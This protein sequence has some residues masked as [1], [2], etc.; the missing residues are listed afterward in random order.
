M[1][2]KAR[3]TSLKKKQG[4]HGINP[5]GKLLD[6]NQPTGQIVSINGKTYYKKTPFK[7]YKMENKSGLL[8][9]IKKRQGTPINKIAREMTIGES[10]VLRGIWREYNRAVK[11]KKITNRNY[12]L[13]P[14]KI[15]RVNANKRS[16]NSNFILAE[17]IDKPTVSDLLNFLN[18]KKPQKTRVNELCEKF[19]KANGLKNCLSSK[20]ARR[21]LKAELGLA[22]KQA[23]EDLVQSAE[24]MR[25]NAKKRGLNKKFTLDV[26]N[27]NLMLESYK[28]KKF[29]FVLIDPLFPQDGIRDLPSIPRT[30]K[31][32]KLEEWENKKPKELYSPKGHEKRINKISQ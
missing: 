10:I 12:S 26:R 32:N 14:M 24:T 16:P 11:T 9:S 19:L 15:L 5:K 28:N 4:F 27:T 6:I 2:R 25:I 18:S 17:F 8:E 21:I 31:R 7:T 22:E 3:R 29:N 1:R 30:K 23:F 20:I 13:R